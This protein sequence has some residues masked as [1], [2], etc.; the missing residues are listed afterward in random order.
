MVLWAAIKELVGDTV[1]R[2]LEGGRREG[3]EAAAEA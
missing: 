1:I 2:C 3:R